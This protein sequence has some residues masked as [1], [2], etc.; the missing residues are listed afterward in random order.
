MRRSGLSLLL[1]LVL[2]LSAFGI[3][4]P[5]IVVAQIDPW[6][7]E[8]PAAAP[9]A[10]PEEEAAEASPVAVEVVPFPEDAGTVTV[11]AAA[12]LTDAFA[13]IERNLEEA[14][15]GLD[16]VN[17]FA[18]SQALVTQLI[19]GAP[20]DVAAFASNTAM[21]NA[22]EGEV[23]ADEPQTFV[24]NL[25]TVVVPSDNPAGITSAADLANDG[26]KLVLAQ[27][28]VPVGG[29]SRESICNM[30]ADTATYGDD[31]LAAVAGNVVSQ[32]DN[33]RAVLTKVAL[34][35]ADAGIVYT[36]DVT[37]DVISILIPEEVNEL[38]TYPIAPVVGGNAEISEAYISY[39]L[40]PEGQDVL[41]NYG[42]IPVD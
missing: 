32:E 6:T 35:E 17:N 36:S 18:G 22:I 9:A 12:S 11:F 13:E 37:E 41:A 24:E 3:Q 5:S 14:N 23:I 2:L 40:S 16:I 42:F 19:E 8:A 25:L 20:A 29:Y 27:E 34:G 15:P 31:F 26:I 39:I 38:A 30:A 33:V 28:D 4:S 21:N 7:C 1:G 10:S